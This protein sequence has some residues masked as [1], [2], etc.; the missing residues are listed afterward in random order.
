MNG[1]SFA[2]RYQNVAAGGS[3]WSF[4]VDNPNSSV[5]TWQLTGGMGNTNLITATLNGNIGL[6][7]T[8]PDPNFRLDVSGPAKIQGNVIV[9]GNGT[10]GGNMIVNGS[11][12]AKYQDLAE[13]VPTSRPMQ[14]GTV[15]VLDRQRSNEVIPSFRAYDTSVAGVISATPGLLLGE[16]GEGKVKVAT[17]GRVKVKVDASQGAIQ[18]GDLL[19]CSDKEG[20]AMRS[21]PVNIVGIQMHRPGT[22]I[23]KA[24]EPLAE[25]E[26]EIL[27][28]LSL[29]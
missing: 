4:V 15:V 26:G 21:E 10:F 1:G 24:L 20:R 2:V 22:L 16:E 9:G 12:G 27:V 13:W 23:G 19:V 11:I 18:V 3:L 28:L 6:G 5:P 29:Q 17:T 14:A 8:A 25:G 7:T